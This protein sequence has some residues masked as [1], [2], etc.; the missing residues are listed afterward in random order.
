ML[1]ELMKEEFELLGARVSIC[2]TGK[3]ALLEIQQNHY[4]ILITDIRM[5]DGTGT[6]L[7]EEVVKTVQPV[8]RIYLCSGYTIE[9]ELIP[10]NLIN[11][12]FKKPIKISEIISEI[13]KD[14]R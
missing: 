2:R 11:K 14:L 4:D 13:E 1:L 9:E 5:P 3:E 10:H 6:W 7:I 12:V 8:P